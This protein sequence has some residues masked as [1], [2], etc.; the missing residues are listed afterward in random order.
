MPLCHV[1]EKLH[2]QKSL[3]NPVNQ[4]FGNNSSKQQIEQFLFCDLVVL[5]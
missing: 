3:K 4:V 5:I 2:A 1:S